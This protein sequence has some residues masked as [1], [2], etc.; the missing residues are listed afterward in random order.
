[1][2]NDPYTQVDPFTEVLKA[3]WALLESNARFTALV[4]EHNRIKI[5]EGAL[6]PEKDKYSSADFPMVEIVPAGNQLNMSASSSS[7]KVTQRYKISMTDGDKRPTVKFFLLK[8]IIFMTLANLD[9]DLGLTYVIN[10][11]LAD[12]SDSPNTEK[13]P[14]WGTEFD[15]DVEMH[16]DRATMKTS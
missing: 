6:K 2:A 1:V 15:V 14:G 5:W 7:A 16:F 11:S 3:L 13:H 8:W 10:T 4:S 12:V 9:K